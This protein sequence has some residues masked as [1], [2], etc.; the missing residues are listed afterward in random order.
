MKK[1]ICR[2]MKDILIDSNNKN[3]SLFSQ[4]LLA[5]KIVSDISISQSKYKFS[6][7]A[8]PTVENR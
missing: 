2:S 3:K 7:K 5:Q 1:T 8:L 6:D 4:V